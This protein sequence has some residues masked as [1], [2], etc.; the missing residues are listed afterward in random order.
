M[1]ILEYQAKDLF[2]KFNINTSEGKFSKV[3][4]TQRIMLDH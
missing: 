4:K 3:E 1:N 2:R